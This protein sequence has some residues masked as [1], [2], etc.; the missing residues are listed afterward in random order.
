MGATVLN[1]HQM[2]EALVRAT[3]AAMILLIA[4]AAQGATFYC[5]PAKGSPQGDGSADRPWRTIEEVLSG[6]LIRLC[7]EDGTAAN[8]AAPVKGGDTVLLRS[9][10]HGVLRIPAGYND[11]FITIAAEQGHAPQVGWVEIGEGRKWLVKGLTVSPSLAPSPLPRT[12]GSLV[13]LG[14]RGG[15]RSRELIVEDCFIYWA[16]D[17]TAWTA[18]DWIEKPGGGIW[19]GR[20]GSRHVA[21]NNYVLN[22]RFG[23]NLC[24]PDCVAEG[25]VVANFSADGIRAT[26]DGQ[27]VQYNVVKNVFVSARDGDDNHDDG[28]QVFLFN[29][30]T[31]MLRDM[32]FR[33]NIIIARENDDLPFP[34][35]LQGLGFFD[36]PLVNFTVEQNVVCVNHFHG[37][38]LYDAQGCTVRDNA[39][40][41]RWN[42]RARPWIMLG[43]KKKQARGNTV[44]DNLAHSFRFEADAEVNEDDNAEVTEAT[45][46]ERLD[47]LAKLIDD[48]FGELHPAAKRPRL[49]R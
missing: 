16:L 29:R 45:F 2:C 5:D 30:G 34:N 40:F 8:P 17:T 15:D 22:T 14:E 4:A 32:V 42:G 39:C 13:T 9:G 23:I 26:R 35:G 36:G 19:L 33:G 24:A 37:I 25:N 12:P 38:S 43:Q 6:K 7:G 11:R 18:K 1:L 3:S 21:R 10:W 27:V 44:A 31:G 20:N 46:R 48:K 47:E 28:V 49:E 41:S